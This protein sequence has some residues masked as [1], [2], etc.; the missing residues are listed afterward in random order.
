MEIK[1][2]R[3]LKSGDFCCVCMCVQMHVC[4]LYFYVQLMRQWEL[5]SLM[6]P[7]FLHYQT[8]KIYWNVI[9]HNEEQQEI[10]KLRVTSKL[11]RADTHVH[12]HIPQILIECYVL[13]T[14]LGHGYITVN[15]TDQTSSHHGACTLVSFLI[16]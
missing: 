3:H 16:C 8:L 2:Y 13:G 14:V 4:T 9:F 11:C 10:N 5:S 15:K 1:M 6:P 12:S 7:C